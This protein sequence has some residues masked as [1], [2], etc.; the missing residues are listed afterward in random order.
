VALAGVYQFVP[1]KRQSLTACRHPAGQ[2]PTTAPP[3]R[4]SFRL[5]FDHGVACLGSSSALMLLMF[6]EGFGNPWW[7]VALTAIMVYET[8]GT[9]GQRVGVVAGVVLLLFAAVV[10]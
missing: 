8:T 4:G 2:L 9:D 10:A 6:A 1:L 7:M 3:R 5:G